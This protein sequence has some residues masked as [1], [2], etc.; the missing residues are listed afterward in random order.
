MN[1][2]DEL[3]NRTSEQMVFDS[4][5]QSERF[6]K[7]IKAYTDKAR[8]DEIWTASTKY[9]SGVSIDKYFIDRLTQLK[10]DK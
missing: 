8:I 5:M 10:G 1:T 2:D 6:R 9:N 3:D 7:V 4:M